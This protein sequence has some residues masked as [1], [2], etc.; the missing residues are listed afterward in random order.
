MFEAVRARRP[1]SLVDFD[2]RLAAVAEF[3]ELDEAVSLAAAN[4][5]TANILRQADVLE[6]DKP[7]ALDPEL[8]VDDAERVLYH[9]MQAARE[10]IVP[11]IEERAYGVAMRRL[12]ELRTPVDAFFDDVMVMADDVA[13]RT[14]RL[15]LL[16]DLRALL[17][18]VADISRLT[19][20]AD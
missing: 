17:V 20:A 15:A 6:S 19:P 12:A 11:L 3:I 1:S 5:R 9:A 14:N 2:Q 16:A 10:D 7:V 4:K 8:L 13:L 18:G